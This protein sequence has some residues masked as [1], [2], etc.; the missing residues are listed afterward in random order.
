MAVVTP[1]QARSAS[2]EFG[3]DDAM[4]AISPSSRRLNV[5]MFL[6]GVT[7]LSATLLLSV[8]IDADPGE[9]LTRHTIRLSLAW[10]FVALAIMLRLDSAGWRAA[11]TAGR[12]ARW[13]WTWGI[14]CFAVHVG[15][16]FHFYHHWSHADAFERTRQISGVGEGIYFS[17]SF[18]ILWLA[19]TAFWWLSPGRYAGRTPWI[20]RL[21]HAF[22]LFMVINGAIVFE[23]GAIRW[24]TAAALVVLATVWIF[25]RSAAR[26]NVER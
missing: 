13:C 19:D 6:A 5:A 14:V 15:M 26:K 12:I 25:S 11:A 3:R 24:A 2:E 17:Y 20:D 21:L 18:G 1:T 4:S 16:A 8:V 9:S 23:T 22:M 7:L 10:Y